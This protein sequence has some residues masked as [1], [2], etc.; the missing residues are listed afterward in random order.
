MRTNNPAEFLESAPK[1]GSVPPSPSAGFRPPV[2]V[3]SV[4]V[5]LVI[6]LA[7]GVVLTGNLAP[8]QI[9]GTPRATP[10][11][12]KAAGT[13]LPTAQAASPD[14]STRPTDPAD[15]HEP[16][17]QQVEAELSSWMSIPQ[18]TS[19]DSTHDVFA[20]FNAV[21]E[22]ACRPNSPLGDL[23]TAISK[24]AWA[25]LDDLGQTGPAYKMWRACI[26]YPT[27]DTGSAAGRHTVSGVD[28]EGFVVEYAM[29]LG[30]IDGRWLV[31]NVTKTG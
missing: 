8:R 31:S 27:D 26:E 25:V 3:L 13:A 29:T 17:R 24:T 1:R 22:L 14:P 30:L 16:G 10:D 28:T 5:T 12:A 15:D 7:G 23:P 20:Y 9:A 4:L 6:G 2:L 19:R 18:R 11:G 21:A